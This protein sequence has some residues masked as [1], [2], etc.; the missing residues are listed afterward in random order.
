MPITPS[1]IVWKIAMVLAAIAALLYSVCG[2]H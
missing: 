1:P 2:P